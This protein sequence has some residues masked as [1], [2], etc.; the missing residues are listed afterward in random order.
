MRIVDK[1]L[2]PH[3]CL[4]LIRHQI[5]HTSPNLNLAK[6]RLL[7]H[8]S[9][10]LTSSSAQLDPNSLC[11]FAAASKKEVEL[12]GLQHPNS[13]PSQSPGAHGNCMLTH[14]PLYLSLRLRLQALKPQPPLP[15]V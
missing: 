12:Q 2:Q 3:H 11:L 10:A 15:G 8:F 5:F 1:R 9:E 13:K 14:P 7:A 6:V 4:L